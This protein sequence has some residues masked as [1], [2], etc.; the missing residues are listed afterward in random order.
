MK[1]PLSWIKDYGAELGY[2]ISGVSAAEFAHKMTMT[3]TMVEGV[4]ELGAEI[5]N[6]VLGKVLSVEKHP[7]AEK[8]VVCQV[9]ISSNFSSETPDAASIVQIVTGAPNV[10]AGALVPVALDG[11]ELPHGK[12]IKTG[13]LRGVRSEGM[14][15]GEDELVDDVPPSDGLWIL[16]TDAEM[17]KNG[18]R[19]PLDVPSKIV[20][21]RTLVPLRAISEAFDARVDWFDDTS[22]ILIQTNVD[23]SYPT[24]DGHRQ[25]NDEI[26]EVA[27]AEYW[28]IDPAE[29]IF[30]NNKGEIKRADSEIISVI[31]YTDYMLK[32][33]DRETKYINTL[34][35]NAKTGERIYL[36][37]V[38]DVNEAFAAK[39]IAKIPKG[40]AL[41]YVKKTYTNADFADM[42]IDVCDFYYAGDSL[43]LSIPLPAR[44]GGHIEV[45]LKL[46]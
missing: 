43:G 37:D 7:D 26:A 21:D 12:K 25:I 45:E 39:V 2:D 34:N 32:D 3:G 46:L 40:D 38:V 36:E 9:Q 35:Y 13:E 29:L 31:F 27:F 42:L 1:F 44:L 20:G 18:A 8:L 24:I 4:T 16:D 28:A 19:I 15:C 11:A 14:M 5:K 23:I 33:S 6:V 17:F 41:D 22:T 10:F 30:F